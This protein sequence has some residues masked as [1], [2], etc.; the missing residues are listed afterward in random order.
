M[1]TFKDIQTKI[2]I[3]SDGADP[4]E[5]ARIAGE[6]IVSG[7]TTNPTLMRKAG[8]TDYEEFARS[9]IRSVPRL[10]VSFE[11]LSDDL[12]EMARQARK[13]SSWGKH[14][15]EDTNHQ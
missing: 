3:F 1:P 12:D 7:F 9:V 11:V 5:I 8:V 14:L 10:P 6:G 4:K 2:K 13:I 15:C